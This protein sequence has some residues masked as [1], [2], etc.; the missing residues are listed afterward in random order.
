MGCFK[1][2]LAGLAVACLSAGP[3]QA[4][5]VT[6]DGPISADRA[7]IDLLKDRLRKL[8]SAPDRRF[9]EVPVSDVFFPVDALPDQA[10]ELRKMGYASIKDH[11]RLVARIEEGFLKQIPDDYDDL[12]REETDHLRVLYLRTCSLRGLMD[13]AENQFSGDAVAYGDIKAWQIEQANFE[14]ALEAA[15]KAP[16]A[17][18]DQV[19]LAGESNRYLDGGVA[20]EDLRKINRAIVRALTEEEAAE[21]GEL[22][23]LILRGPCIDDFRQ[24]TTAFPGVSAPLLPPDP[25]PP[26]SPYHPQ[27]Y[28][29]V[30][31]PAGASQVLVG[32]G[33]E[34]LL[35]S[36]RNLAW[37]S[38]ACGFKPA[39]NKAALALRRHG[40]HVY[41]A[42]IGSQW[43]KG[44]FDVNSAVLFELP[45]TPG[46]SPP[47]V[48]LT[49]AP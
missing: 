6:A 19:M 32:R 36:R 11:P 12:P 44:Q 16:L 42:R 23:V 17:E 33:M 8:P 38:T 48:T 47:V 28:F 29:A 37:E 13:E 9:V 40:R 46:E 43:A 22:P 30:A 27:K 18:E 34:G 49:P 35:C 26:P 15:F 2:A 3:A 31:W 24:E 41:V 10:A 21:E 39:G 5:S 7:M 1:S 45:L 25:P 14:L 4:Q 20:D